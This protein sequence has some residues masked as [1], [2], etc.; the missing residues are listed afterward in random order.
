M[1]IKIFILKLKFTLIC[2]HMNKQIVQQLYKLAKA[3]KIKEFMD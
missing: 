3:Q 1:N 2:D